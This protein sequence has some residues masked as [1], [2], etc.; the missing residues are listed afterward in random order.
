M[1]SP[2]A[3]ARVAGACYVLT[4]ILGATAFSVSNPKVGDALNFFAALFY[5]AVTLLFYR[6][7]RAVNTG[8][9]ALA[10]L[11]SLIGCGLQLLDTFNIN[12]LHVNN[13]IFFGVYCLLI[14]LLLTRASFLPHWLAAFMALAGFSWLTY[15]SR[16]LGRE[17]SSY[18]FLTGLVGEG[19]LTLW[20]LIKGVDASRWREQALTSRQG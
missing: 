2:V 10:A 8:L 9:S 19:A 16:S 18:T 13:I 1:R 15:L 4:T 12:P 3:E 17:L 20:L 5:I 11:F 6:L 14:A 7:F